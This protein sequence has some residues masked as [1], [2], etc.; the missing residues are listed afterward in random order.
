MGAHRTLLSITWAEIYILSIQLDCGNFVKNFETSAV[1]NCRLPF[2]SSFGAYVYS[3]ALK[4]IIGLEKTE[5]AYL[6]ASFWVR[7]FQ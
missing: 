7:T 4:S 2:Q 6:N 1:N 5:G 3:Y